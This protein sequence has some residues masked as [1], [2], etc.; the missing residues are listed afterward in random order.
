MAPRFVRNILFVTLAALG[1][2]SRTPAMAADD[3][4]GGARHILISYRSAPEARPAFRNYL[5]NTEAKMLDRL[6]QQGVLKEYQILFNPFANV[7]TWDAMLVLDFSSFEAT[8]R[9]QR[10]ER[11]MP[12]GL[13]PAGLKLGKPYRT[14]SADLF[15]DA[16]AS[17]PGD[18]AKHVLY[19]IPYTY[20]DAGQYKSYVD[21]YVIPQVKGWMKEGV[22][23]RYRIYMNRYPV[24]D[25]EPWDA[26]FIYD[27]RDLPSVG[28]REEILAKVRGPLRDNPEW[29]HLSDI[30]A[31]IRSE[32]ENTTA[33]IIA[34]SK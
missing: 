4:N 9:W 19:V 23:S 17:D 29:K 33:E 22:L 12:G 24:G 32:A 13:A 30:K 20:N 2:L 28:R 14:Y 31:T 6:R 27:Y 34:P 26:L 18:A 8:A 25:P 16:M 11:T 10:I 1:A 5:I 21:G 15:R 7:G 3:M